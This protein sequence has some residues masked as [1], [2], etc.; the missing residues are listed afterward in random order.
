MIHLLESKALRTFCFKK[1]TNVKKVISSD[2]VV[3]IKYD[4][5]YSKA[6]A[7]AKVK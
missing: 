2:G 3:R 7:M 5:D 4:V 6:V 1:E